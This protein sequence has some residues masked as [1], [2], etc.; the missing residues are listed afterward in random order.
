MPKVSPR[1]CAGVAF[2]NASKHSKDCSNA[3]LFLY[4][5]YPNL[6]PISFIYILCELA[7][8]I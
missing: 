7:I 4:I 8:D 1:A 6:P 2:K 5:I 3:V